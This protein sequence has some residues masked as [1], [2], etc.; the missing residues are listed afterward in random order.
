MSGS[1]PTRTA[2]IALAAVCLVGQATVL[3]DEG[4][5]IERLEIKYDLQRDGAIRVAEAIDVDFGTLRKHGIFRDVVRRQIYDARRD[6]E[7]DVRLVG[8][9]NAAGARQPVKVEDADALTRFRIGDADR[10]ISGRQAYRIAYQLG[11]ALNALPDHDEFYWNATGLWPVTMARAII[12]VV[13]PEAGIERVA[14]FQG[15]AGSDEPCDVRFSPAEATFTA[16][17]PLAEH[18]QITVV[19]GLRKGLLAVPAP[20]LVQRARGPSEWFDRGS[21]IVGTVV[22][23]AVFFLGGVLFLWWRFGRD[24]RYVAIVR[25][26]GATA[27]ERI[28]LFGG[29][30][31]AVEFTPPDN[32]RPGQMGLLLDERADTLD[33]TATIVDLA[34]RGYLRIDEV[35]KAHW[36]SRKDWQLERLKPSDK[37][38]HPYERIVLDGLF[39]AGSPTRLSSLKTKFHDDLS[40][41]QASLY[42][43]AV[44]R[45][46]FPQNPR[47]VRAAWAFMGVVIAAA[48]VGLAIW[49]GRWWGAGWLAVPVLLCGFLV[50][51]TSRAM[52]RR[53][54]PGQELTRRTLGF[55][56]YIRTAEAQPQAFAERAHLFTTYLPYAIAFRCVDRWAKAF[57]DLDLQRATASWYGGSSHFNAHTFS[58][59]LGSFS[60]TL[61]TAI[62]TTPGGSGGS[63]FSGGSSGGGGG[64]GGGGSW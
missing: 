30:P 44:A 59:N 18:E 10:E 17:R 1:R 53:A 47:S 38:L 43:E 20:T 64:G 16:T 32:L 13:V 12:R 29:R 11:G 52:P 31:V 23:E 21:W 63:G 60:S 35:D 8:V 55:V 22:A 14:C 34:V 46:W 37:D 6:R 15:V 19:V 24:R 40:R 26:A 57:E 41:A 27:D 25:T 62:S 45:G 28:P 54:A 42:A 7:Y 5:V 39:E 61:S 4:W 56:R 33:V 36:F 3:A 2:T 49:L 50:A 9:L 58:S 48:G 51:A